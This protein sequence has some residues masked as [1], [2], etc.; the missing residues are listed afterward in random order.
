VKPYLNATANLIRLATDPQAADAS[1]DEL[2]KHNSLSGLTEYIDY[3]GL[4][5]L[6]FENYATLPPQQQHGGFASALRE[7]SIK[8]IVQEHEQQAAIE[9]IHSTLRD[10]GIP[11]VFFKGAA[12]RYRLYEKPHLRPAAD[13]DILVAREHTT[14]AARALI[15]AGMHPSVSDTNATH[16][17]ILRLNKVE[18]DLHWHL[19]RPGRIRDGI[20]KD[21]L[22]G[23]VLASNGLP[24]PDPLSSLFIQLVHPTYTKYVSSP[25]A[26]DIRIVDF[27][28]LLQQYDIAWPELAEWLA[29]YNAR[30][31]AWCTLTWFL[32][33]TDAPVPDHF[34]RSVAPSPA[35]Q[36]YLKQWILGGLVP[37]YYKKKNLMRIAFTLFAQD[38]YKDMARAT[39]R[40]LSAQARLKAELTK[41]RRP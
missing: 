39:N 27:L 29:R 23:K 11:H 26:K 6:C 37:R 19:L 32:A 18:V 21:I 22:E 8:S 33:V 38:S 17:R 3:N 30:T 7:T 12:S 41:D 35:R 31:A 40:Y 9:T 10:A 36:W 24:V 13:I 14:E 2:L 20:E 4:G 34:L 28:R 15:S 1:A 5:P 25:W 16:E